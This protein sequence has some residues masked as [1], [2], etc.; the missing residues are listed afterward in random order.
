MDMKKAR[1]KVH[2][3]LNTGAVSGTEVAR[4]LNEDPR[5]VLKT[6]VTISSDRNLL[7][8]LIPVAEELDLKA[9]A[10]SVGQ[11]KI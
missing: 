1:Y 3:Y 8:F 4:I 9:A 6:L 11:K 5:Q 2:T 10:R 7:V